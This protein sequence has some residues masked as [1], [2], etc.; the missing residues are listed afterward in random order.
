MNFKHIHNFLGQFESLKFFEPLQKI[1]ALKQSS[2]DLLIL[3][4]DLLM[5]RKFEG[6]PA[7]VT[8]SDQVETKC[9]FREKFLYL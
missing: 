3:D 2:N 6:I 4:P 7:Q 1:A 9:Y 8:S 5:I